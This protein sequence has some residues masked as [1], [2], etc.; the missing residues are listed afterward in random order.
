MLLQLKADF[1]AATGQDWKPGMAAKAA[2][3]ARTPNMSNALNK[4]DNTKH[5]GIAYSS[6]AQKL[7]E[8]N[9]LRGSRSTCSEFTHRSSSSQSRKRQISSKDSISS[10]TSEMTPNP[11]RGLRWSATH[12]SF[13]FGLLTTSSE[14][15][16]AKTYGSVGKDYNLEILQYRSRLLYKVMIRLYEVAR[17]L[18]AAKKGLLISPDDSPFPLTV[19]YDGKLSN[20]EFVFI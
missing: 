8:L 19:E 10:A 9:K 7:Q 14:A 13:H 17:E 20:T 5:T 4:K 18:N 1:K 16:Q 6:Q 11:S 3:P 15:P 12:V 2:S